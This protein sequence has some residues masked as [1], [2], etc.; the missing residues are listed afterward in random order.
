MSHYFPTVMLHCQWHTTSLS[1][2]CLPLSCCSARKGACQSHATLPRT[3][4]PLSGYLAA[5]S[6]C[7]VYIP[8]PLP[9][10][11][12]FYPYFLLIQGQTSLCKSIHATLIVSYC[13]AGV[14]LLC[15]CHCSLPVMRLA[16]VIALSQ[17]SSF[18]CVKLLCH[19]HGYHHITLS[20][21]YQPHTAL[22]V[23]YC[24]ATIL[25]LPLSCWFVSIR[26][27][28]TVVQ[29][30]YC[31]GTLLYHPD[32]IIIILPCHSVPAHSYYSSGAINSSR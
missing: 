23:S 25:L 10:R 9:S 32:F 19:A 24:L 22:L 27:L 13:F 20:S 17:S 21:P 18:A 16:T 26:L 14:I 11:F 6:T 12:K 5:Y 29:L 8:W 15:H 31:R 2:R 7:Y 28:A 3:V 1:S 4:T 30:H